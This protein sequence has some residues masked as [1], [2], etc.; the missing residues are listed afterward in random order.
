MVKILL[1][2]IEHRILDVSVLLGIHLTEVELYAEQEVA[3]KDVAVD[4]FHI[5]G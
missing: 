2:H 3:A 4:V 5:F 1:H